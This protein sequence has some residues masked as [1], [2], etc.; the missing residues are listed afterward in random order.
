MRYYGCSLQKALL[1]TFPEFKGILEPLY[2][3]FFSLILIPPLLSDALTIFTQNEA[4]ASPL[5]GHEVSNLRIFLDDIAQEKRFDPRDFHSWESI[6]NAE[7][8][9]RV[10][11]YLDSSCY[12]CSCADQMLAGWQL[13]AEAARWSRDSDQASVS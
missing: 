1:D 5:P 2:Y 7:I 9:K 13:H 11:M 3:I 6:G 8:N 10:C 12:G 4:S